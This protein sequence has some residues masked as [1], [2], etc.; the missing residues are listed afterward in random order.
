V[1]HRV[2]DAQA[3]EPAALAALAVLLAVTAAWWALAF[4][5]TSANAAWL[6]RARWVCFGVASNGLP[7]AQGWVAL[8][9]QPV[10]MFGTLLVGWGDA[11]RSGL[12]RLSARRLGQVSLTTTALLVMG[13]L[14]GVT[15]RVA[16]AVEAAD[17]SVSGGL[18][19]DAHPRLG[20]A[21]PRLGL[22]DQHGDSVFMEQFRGRPVLV[23]FAFGHCETVCP[24]VVHDVLA[25]RQRLPDVDPQV[26]VISLDPWRD[27]PARLP[28]IARQWMLGESDLALSGDTVTVNRVLD[29]WKV[30]RERNLRTGD[31]VHP[32]LVYIV[33]GDGKVAY[34]SAG[35]VETIVELVRRSER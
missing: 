24:V 26:V 22:V 30:G 33:D 2:R 14:A 20:H 7:D 34:A 10:L 5:P 23:T 29:E 4:W 19:P 11:V 17:W 13:G 9:L 1:A 21:A 3:R 16:R 12:R 28:S 6:G 25:A 35:T 27:V 31:I 8:I 18:D 15:V 32:R